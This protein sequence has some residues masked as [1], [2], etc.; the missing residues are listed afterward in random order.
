[1]IC[2]FK[3]ICKIK[4]LHARVTQA[5]QQYSTLVSTIVHTCGDFYNL[6]TLNE[7]SMSTKGVICLMTLMS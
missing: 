6:I 7:I 2:F 1:M 5:L 4:E 3:I